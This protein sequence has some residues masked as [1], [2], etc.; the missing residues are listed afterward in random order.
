MAEYIKRKDVERNLFKIPVKVDEDGYS[1]I[2]LRNAFSACSESPSA[3]V[4]ERTFGKWEFIDSFTPCC[5]ECGVPPIL[6]WR[7]NEVFS[8]YCPSC[9]ARM[10]N[11]ED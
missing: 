4:V 11:S 3:D 2:L 8:R 6:D 9:G 10:V 1:W 7:E 5:S